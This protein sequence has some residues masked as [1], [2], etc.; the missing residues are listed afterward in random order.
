MNARYVPSDLVERALAKLGVTATDQDETAWRFATETMRRWYWLSTYEERAYKALALAILT[1]DD[2]RAETAA[3][4][5]V[6]P[7]EAMERALAAASQPKLDDVR[8]A[9]S[10]CGDAWLSD[11]LARYSEERAR[12]FLRGV[13]RSCDADVIACPGAPRVIARADAVKLSHEWLRGAR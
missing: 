5:I 2:A 13:L 7:D 8:A 1:G 3:L 12:L 4:W 9:W 11:D 6:S 10:A